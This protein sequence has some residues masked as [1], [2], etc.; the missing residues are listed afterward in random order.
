MDTELLKV[1]NLHSVIRTSGGP[2]RAV[3]GVSFS[4][5]PRRTLGLVGESGCGKTVTALSI[6][7]LLQPPV[8]IESGSILFHSRRGNGMANRSGPESSPAVDLLSLS[9]RGIRKIRG[10]EI[11]MVFQEPST[12]LNPVMTV[13]E[14]IAETVR[15]HER[16]SRKESWRRAVETMEAIA[17]ADAPRLAKEYPHQLSGGLRQRVMIAMALV[18]RP[19]LLIADEPTTALDVT[20]QAQ[21]LE[22]LQVMQERFALSML[23]ISHDLGVIA[24]VAD[25]VAVMYCGRIVEQAPVEELFSNPRHP[26]TQGLLRSLPAMRRGEMPSRKLEAI[27]GTV[28]NLME[29]SP[30]CKFEPRCPVRIR[31]C[32]TFDPPLYAV[33]N[34]HL[35]RCV[36]CRPDEK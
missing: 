22:L 1:S 20:V 17:I 10:A 34:S 31:E 14:Q 23:F 3:D 33:G 8:Y 18:C 26:Y 11:A 9:E 19:Q 2:L 7:R 24:A 28:P 21:I 35:G 36:L 13:G 15:A 27:P 25:E 16:V 30:G 6:L 32:K 4:I 5:L 12:A 29:L